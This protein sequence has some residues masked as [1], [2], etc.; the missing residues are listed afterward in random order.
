MESHVKCSYHKRHKNENKQTKTQ[1]GKRKPLEVMDMLITL[2]VV[3]VSWV[4][5]Y[6]KTQQTVYFKYVQFL[7]NYTSIKLSKE[8]FEIYSKDSL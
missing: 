8:K 5:A 2:I 3:M 1:R 4:Y 7:I 6:V